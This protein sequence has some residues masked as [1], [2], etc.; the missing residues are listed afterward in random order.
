[1]NKHIRNAINKGKAVSSFT[2]DRLKERS[3]WL[4]IV[5]LATVSGYHI[6]PDQVNTLA[7]FG[8][9]LTG[10]ILAGTKG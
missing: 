6:A 7:E 8:V 10:A 9:I 4:G 1:M 2:A 3:T 5:A